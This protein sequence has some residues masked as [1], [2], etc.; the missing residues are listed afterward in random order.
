MKI[1]SVR[2]ADSDEEA[3]NKIALGLGCYNTHGNASW[4]MMLPMIARG[5]FRVTCPGKREA[6]V[7]FKKSPHWWQPD[8][9]N[10]M[11]A[12]FVAGK[13][14]APIDELVDKG[15]LPLSGDRL[16][17][18][19]NGWKSQKWQGKPTKRESWWKPIE[20]STMPVLDAVAASEFSLEKLVAGG[21]ILSDCKLW[22]GCPDEWTG[23]IYGKK[24]LARESKAA[25][26]SE[27]IP[28]P[29][30]VPLSPEK[31]ES[32]RLE[33]EASEAEMRKRQAEEWAEIRASVTPE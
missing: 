4:R 5:M 29:A 9:D 26:T 2:M 19:W 25:E 3:L 11:P 18:T 12:A 20:D 1:T 32:M 10:A 30:A 31:I 6:Y 16:A 14:K 8:A 13:Y 17:A 24:D 27:P 23:W 7:N 21:L 33:R 28:K 22:L 15:F